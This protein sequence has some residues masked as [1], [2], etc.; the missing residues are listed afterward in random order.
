MEAA[1]AAEEMTRMYVNGSGRTLLSYFVSFNAKC[2]V[3]LLFDHVYSHIT[4]KCNTFLIK[5]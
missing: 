1:L 5:M 3:M 4:V 2:G